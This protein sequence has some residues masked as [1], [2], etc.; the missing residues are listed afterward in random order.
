ME[1]AI[2]LSTV[3]FVSL[4]QIAIPFLVKRTVAFGVTIPYEQTRNPKV[5]KYKKWYAFVT[6]VVALAV[7]I[8]LIVL[9]TILDETKL[10]LVGSLF[11]FF[12]LFSGLSLYFYFH[13]KITKLKKVHEWYSGI[14]QVH[15]ADLDARSKDEM[16]AS[17]VHFIPM[18]ITVT[19]IILTVNL[20]EQLP[21]QIP[22]H[23]G[24]DGKPDAFTDKSWMS[25]LNL[26]IVLFVLQ[27]MFFG[28]NFFTKR[29]GIK[30]NAG[31]VTSSKLRQL[32]LR[33]YSSWFLFVTN[34]IMTLLFAGLQLNLLYEQLFSDSFLLLL[35]FVF[36]LVVLVGALWLAVKVG[37]VDSDLEGK[38]VTGE[39]SKIESVDEDSYWKGGLFYFNPNDPSIFVEKRFGIGWTLNLANPI[40]YFVILF[41]IAIILILSFLIFK[42]F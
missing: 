8:G 22:T 3:L 19:L 40:G 23:W 20:F 34:I 18:I 14:K 30:I 6:T 29:S 1:L 36:L 13:Y 2:F 12:V 41:P 33:K 9:S 17:F 27:L 15:Y 32:R 10:V 28:I 24:P 42:W 7:I 37:R 4:I 38:L 11:P 5:L 39:S 31:N 21:N 25:V 26:P 16:L 35:P